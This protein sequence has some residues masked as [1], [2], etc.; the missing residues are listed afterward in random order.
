[1]KLNYVP[2][3]VIFFFPISSKAISPTTIGTC[4]LNG[5]LPSV[6][7]LTESSVCHNT[8]ACTGKRCKACTATVAGTCQSKTCV[9]PLPACTSVALGIECLAPAP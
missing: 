5:Q 2:L 8:F 9:S 6:V 7:C 3:A 4:F 1:M